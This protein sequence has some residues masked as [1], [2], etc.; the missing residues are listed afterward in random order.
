MTENDKNMDINELEK[1]AEGLPVTLF[2]CDI[3]ASWAIYYITHNVL[4]LSGYSKEDFLTQKVVW[5]DIV[6]PEDV[7]KIDAAI[8]EAM[9]NNTPYNVEYRIKRADG[10]VIYIEEKGHLISDGEGNYTY[11][12]GVFLNIDKYVKAEEDSKR[13]I[14]ESLPAPALALYV[15]KTGKVQY[16]NEYVEE[17][18]IAGN[19]QNVIIGKTTSELMA[20]RNKTVVDTVLET[21]ESV[22]NLEKTINLT[23]TDH[24]LYTVISCVPIRDKHGEIAGALNIMIDL[25]ELKTKEKEI[26]GML[27]YTNDCLADLGAGIRRVSEGYIDVTLEKIKDDD[28]GKTFDEFNTFTERLRGILKDIVEGMNETAEEVRHSEEAVTQMNAGMEQISTAAEQIATGSENLS[29]HAN[30]SAADVKTAEQIF[31]ELNNSS[32]KSVEFSAEAVKISEVTKELGNNALKDLD[33]IV[34]E[35]EQLG[36]IVSSLDGAVNNIG[37]VSEK[38]QSIA[39]QTNLLALNAAIEAARAGEHGR[40][41][42][43][44]ADEVRKLAEESRKSTDEIKGIVASVQKE[45]E[46]VTEAINRA[47]QEA[48]GGSKDI[49]GALSKAAEIAEMVAKINVMLDEV[50]EKSVEGLERIESI[51]N[52]IGEVASTAEENAASSEETSAAIEEQTAAAQQVTTSMK[53]VNDLAQKTHKMLMENFKISSGDQ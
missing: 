53:H 40:G 49:E 23:F 45:T 16:I 25:T 47:K 43:V 51:D 10:N 9:K 26:E 24:E 20:S 3:N 12:D 15:D 11:L 2:R 41:F 36:G 1:F 39:D 37:V 19:P 42:A 7:A 35:I 27:A 4:A 34:D 32:A 46:R 22:Q 6:I 30:V 33:V 48:K 29:R 28:F 31:R 13:S 5:S 18:C 52:N 8:D 17:L 50:T 14:V 44:V 21:G 38:I